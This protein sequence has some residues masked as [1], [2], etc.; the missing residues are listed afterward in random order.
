[1]ELLTPSAH[2]F[3]VY[4][5][6]REAAGFSV[7]KAKSDELYKSLCATYREIEK[8]GDQKT[9]SKITA[10]DKILSEEYLTLD[11]YEQVMQLGPYGV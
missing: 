11:F 6:H 3:I 1:M 8:K 10:I 4:G 5:G 9:S 7:S 2:L